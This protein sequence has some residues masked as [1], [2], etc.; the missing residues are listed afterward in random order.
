MPP[1]VRLT[2]ASRCTHTSGCIKLV[3]RKAPNS[4]NFRNVC[5]DHYNEQQTINKNKCSD[6]DCDNYDPSKTRGQCLHCRSAP[7]PHPPP[8][9]SICN[10]PC[11]SNGQ[12]YYY[13]LCSQH[14]HQQLTA[15][16]RLCNDPYCQSNQFSPA[17]DEPCAACHNK[18]LVSLLEPWQCGKTCF[19]KPCEEPRGHSR[20]GTYQWPWCIQH[21]LELSFAGH[22][23]HSEDHGW[24]PLTLA[25]YSAIC[26]LPVSEPQPSDH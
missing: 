23:R 8:E 7:A 26:A 12:G 9:C 5:Q 22:V 10:Q 4:D 14:R 25:Q 17:T 3:I 1:R 11:A 18:V 13:T 21:Q 19:G 20:D 2:A 6:P 24:T 16:D 15:S